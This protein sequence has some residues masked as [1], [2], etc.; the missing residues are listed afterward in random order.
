M[1]MASG[2]LGAVEGLSP[3]PGIALSPKGGLTSPPRCRIRTQMAAISIETRRAPRVAAR[4]PTEVAFGAGRWV[5]PHRG[6][7]PGRLLH[8]GPA[9]APAR[10]AGLA[11]APLRGRRLHPR[12]G[13][14]GGLDRTA[15]PVADRRGVRAR[16]G[17]QGAPL[18]PRGAGRVS[19]PRRRERVRRDPHARSDCARS[20]CTSR[21]PSSR[22]APATFA[23]SSSPPAPGGERKRRSRP[24]GACG[25][26]SSSRRAIPRR[27]GGAEEARGRAGVATWWPGGA[28]PSGEHPDGPPGRAFRSRHGLLAQDWRP[29][30][31]SMPD[32]DAFRRAPRLPA[33]PP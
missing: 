21:R 14:H 31:T 32:T 3:D 20:P 8:R 2:P 4:C 22:R 1:R 13:G 28:T 7:R 29:R 9:G 15:A 30:R 6:P 33:H 27:A 24:S 5:R 12:R 26:R 16:P 23:R 11:E 19:R 18:R 10:R 17:G 25:R